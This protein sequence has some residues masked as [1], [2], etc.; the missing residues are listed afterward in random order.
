MMDG[1]KKRVLNLNNNILRVNNNC[2]SKLI[3]ITFLSLTIFLINVIS[4]E[5]TIISPAVVYPGDIIT[6]TVSPTKLGFYNII[7]VYKDA[8]LVDLINVPCATICKKRQVVSYVVPAN[9]LGD[10]YF[11]TFDYATN[12]YE[13]DYFKVIEQ[14]GA[15]GGALSISY[16]GNTNNGVNTLITP[17]QGANAGI[18]IDTQLK[19]SNCQTYI[20]NAYLCN[21]TISAFCSS[22]NYTIK[23][24]LQLKSQTGKNCRFGYQGM[25][26]FPFYQP[27]DNWKL[28]VKSGIL[29]IETI[30][31][32]A[33]LAAISYP[34]V[35]DFGQLNARQW[36]IGVPSS[37][38]DLINHGN[39]PVLLEWTSSGFTCIEPITCTD[40]WPT[41]ENS[42][43]ENTFQID[44]DE[45]FL[46][47]VQDETGIAPAFITN[48]QPDYFPQNQL[49]LCISSICLD[50]VGERY[51][52][53]F[54]LKI[55]E[56]QRGSYEGD[57]I[58]TIS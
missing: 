22:A 29:S 10:Y 44:D 1:Y 28:Y 5:I 2:K 51:K 38:L 35:I 7:Y 39:V 12:N 53:Y 11:A 37:G 13:L 47:P 6:I 30:F 43:G 52:T 8:T 54:N 49:A 19:A 18:T 42:T 20:V 3:F 41:F 25:D 14:G 21:S 50:G 58:L 48:Y 23:I 27:G 15:L 26:Y 9:F 32:Y 24:P 17:E 57:V 45:F 31:D 56:I 33:S 16:I 4:A 36:N 40:F 55:P 34:S 46:E